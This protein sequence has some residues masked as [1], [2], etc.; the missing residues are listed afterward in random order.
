MSKSGLIVVG[1]T[2]GFTSK[3]KPVAKESPQEFFLAQTGRLQN[4]RRFE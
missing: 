4:V 3:G 2:A 1:N